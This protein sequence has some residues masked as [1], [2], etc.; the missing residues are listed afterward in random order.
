MNK[1]MIHRIKTAGEYQR[2]AVRALFPAE[3]GEHIDVIEKELKM[4]VTEEAKELL[5]EFK[6]RDDSSD[7]QSREKTSKVKKVNIS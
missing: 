3:M 2:K 1:E 7:G 4:M 5:K 6:M